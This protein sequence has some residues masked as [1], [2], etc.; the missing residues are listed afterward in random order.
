VYLAL[1]ILLTTV[2]FVQF[3]EFA[4]YKL[5]LLQVIAINYCVCVLCGIALQPA[6]VQTVLQSA[7]PW[8]WFA[9]FQGF[10][11]MAMF[12][13]TGQS[14]QRAGLGY[15]TMVTKMSVVTPML[16]SLFVFNERLDGY[17]WLGIVFA[18]AAIVLV[19][20]RYLQGG[21]THADYRQLVLWGIVLFIGTGI[22]DANFKIF[23]EVFGGQASSEAFTL[24][25][26]FFAAVTGLLALAWQTARGAER[27]SVG[28]VAGGIALGVPNYFTVLFLLY[29][30]KS[31]PGAQ[32]YPLNNIGLL[33]LATIIGV[34]RYKEHLGW[35]GW[36]G[37]GLAILAIISLML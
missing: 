35:S 26:F 1:C 30:L 13:L 29:G 32:F 8:L 17:Q 21:A 37:L 18:L 10:L 5:S 25:V 24:A 9:L 14:A 34:L 3:R 20:L 23:K 16:V 19:H 27:I 11:F 12:L 6:I 15:T 31:I 28:N 33:V 2:L 36:A 4:R 22:T 7:G